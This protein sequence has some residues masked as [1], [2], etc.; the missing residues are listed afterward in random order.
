MAIAPGVDEPENSAIH[1]AD[2]RRA[3]DMNEK[4]FDMVAQPNER[5]GN[6]VNS[7][8]LNCFAAGIG[9][10][11]GIL[12]WEGED[13]C[14]KL[15]SPCQRTVNNRLI[16]TGQEAGASRFSAI[17]GNTARPEMTFKKPPRLGA[18]AKLFAQCLTRNALK[19]G[20][21]G[22]GAAQWGRFRRDRR[23]GPRKNPERFEVIVQA[24][25]RKFSERN[26]SGQQ[27]RPFSRYLLRN[28]GRSRSV[29]RQNL[30]AV[31]QKG[32]PYS[33]RTGP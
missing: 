30:G 24:E 12:G 33:V 19:R 32:E 8:G 29:Q 22:G 18:I 23:A 17:A 11:R 2:P 25:T 26:R 16:V 13:R 10:R 31:R 21:G 3:L 20:G 1:E 14:R 7:A 28:R 5:R 9:S 27:M 6:T 15:G 4:N